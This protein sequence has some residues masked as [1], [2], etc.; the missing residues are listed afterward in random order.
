VVTSNGKVFSPIQIQDARNLAT[1]GVALQTVSAIKEMPKDFP[2]S[3]G[4]RT[5]KPAGRGVGFNQSELENVR[6]AAAQGLSA[7]DI[8][9]RT[10]VPVGLLHELHRQG[11]LGLQELPPP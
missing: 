4:I 6:N 2:A 5:I 7:Q 1:L 9:N 10:G 11:Y 8:T 3:Q